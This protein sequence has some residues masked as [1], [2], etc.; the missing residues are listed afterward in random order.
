MPAAWQQ[1]QALRCSS[2]T[3]RPIRTCGFSGGGGGGLG[4]LV[5]S[6]R[7]GHALLPPVLAAADFCFGAAFLAHGSSAARALLLLAALTGSELLS[8]AAAEKESFTDARRVLAARQSWCSSLALLTLTEN[9]LAFSSSPPCAKH[10]MLSV[11]HTQ[12]HAT[13]DRSAKG[14]RHA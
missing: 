7:S 12:A 10:V 11:A 14:G 2:R 4:A 8:A 5:A 9:S 13:C 1:L 3:G 6:G